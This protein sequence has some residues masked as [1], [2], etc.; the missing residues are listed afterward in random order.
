MGRWPVWRPGAGGRHWFPG[1][2]HAGPP[3]A[4]VHR[5]ARPERRERG[6][7]RRRA[8]FLRSDCTVR[9]GWV[10]AGMPLPYWIY[11]GIWLVLILVAVVTM[12]ES[13][14]PGRRR[15]APKWFILAIVLSFCVV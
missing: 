9:R 5:L 14:R 12:A 11:A 8:D 13:L 6:P 1:L 3:T 10:E 7:G 4:R 15:E 2:V